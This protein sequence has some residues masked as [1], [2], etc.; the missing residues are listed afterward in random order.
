MCHQVL[1]PPLQAFNTL[2]AETPSKALWKVKAKVGAPLLHMRKSGICE[3]RLQASPHNLHF[4]QLGHLLNRFDNTI[5]IHATGTIARGTRLRYC[6][7][8]MSSPTN[9]GQRTRVAHQTKFGFRDVPENERQGLVNEVFATVAERYDLMNDLMSGG[10][11]RLWKNDLIG[12]LNP[13][14]NDRSFRLL[15]VAGGTGDVAIRYARASGPNATAVLCDISQ[16]M[17]SVGR[18]KVREAGLDQRVTLTQGNAEALPFPDRKFDA[19]TI[20]FGIRNVTHIDKTLG[21]AFRGVR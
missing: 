11:H 4:G 3:H 19:Y 10:L 13:P 5:A 14:R 15:D 18:R 6:R 12:W 2:T 17:L 21:E 8:L 7:R 9:E 16:E 20:A 1:G